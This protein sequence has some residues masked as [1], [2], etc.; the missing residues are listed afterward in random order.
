MQAKGLQSPASSLIIS[1]PSSPSLSHAVR[2]PGHGQ[3]E[4]GLPCLET[5]QTCY[6]ADDLVIKCGNVDRTPSSNTAT[7]PTVCRR[8]CIHHTK[9]QVTQQGEPTTSGAASTAHTK[10]NCSKK[11]ATWLCEI[12]R[13]VPLPKFDAQWT[14]RR[15]DR[16]INSTTAHAMY[17]RVHYRLQ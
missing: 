11:M 15:C 6:N 12:C 17:T 2:H 9:Q 13:P 8:V 16:K 4:Q 14:V 3:G 7:R 5:F 10:K 1:L